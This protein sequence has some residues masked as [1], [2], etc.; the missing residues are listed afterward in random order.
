MKLEWTSPAIDDLEAIIEFI[1]RDSPYHA[2]AFAQEMV[3]RI[4]YLL[5]FPQIGRLVPEYDRNDIRELRF[6]NYRIIY[7]VEKDRILVLTII[8]GKREL[9][10][11]DIDD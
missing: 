10:S 2:K 5:R 3:Q 4:E 7:H 8:H 6:Q 9:L 1:S 11:N